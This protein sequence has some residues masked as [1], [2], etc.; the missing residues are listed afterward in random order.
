MG[1]GVERMRRGVESEVGGE[2]EMKRG[3]GII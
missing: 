2:V 3:S 1:E